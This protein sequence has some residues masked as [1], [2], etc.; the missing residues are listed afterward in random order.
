MLKPILDAKT[1]HVTETIALFIAQV[2]IAIQRREFDS[3]EQS[4][5]LLI[6]LAGKDDPKVAQLRRLIDTA[7]HGRGLRQLLSRI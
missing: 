1:L 7:S 6:E 4:L 5:A 2:Q 3:A